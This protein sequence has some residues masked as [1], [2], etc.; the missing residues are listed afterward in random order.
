[1]RLK[2]ASTGLCGKFRGRKI[3]AGFI[4]QIPGHTTTASL[5]R[6]LPT[7]HWSRLNFVGSIDCEDPPAAG[8]FAGDL[9]SSSARNKRE[10]RRIPAPT[11]LAI[12]E[13]TYCEEV[14]DP[15]RVIK[16]SGRSR[17]HRPVSCGITKKT[18]ERGFSLGRCKFVGGQGRRVRAELVYVRLVLFSVSPIYGLPARVA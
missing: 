7:A 13:D 14:G 16:L 5:H 4:R 18:R 9:G 6:S 12:A 10:K 15:A 3:A 17:P 1:M 8:L 11:C 2:Q